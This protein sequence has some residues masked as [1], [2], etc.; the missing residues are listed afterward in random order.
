MIRDIS[1]VYVHIGNSIPDYLFDTIYQSLL[2]NGSQIKIYIIVNDD[3]IDMIKKKVQTFDFSQYINDFCFNSVLQFIPISIL[4]RSLENNSS[5]DQYKTVMNQK[6]SNLSHFRDGFWISTTARFYYIEMLI[7]M[8]HLQNVFHIENDVM[9]YEPIQ[10]IYK[11]INCNGHCD[12]D[13]ICMVQ[14]APDRVIPSLMFFPNLETTKELTKYITN[15]IVCSPNFINDMNILGSF[16]N[17]IELNIYPDQNDSN[18]NSNSNS[19]SKVV[20]DGAA[21]GQYLGGVDYKN[22]PDPDNLINQ[23]WNKSKGFVNE[24]CMM[25][26][27]DYIFHK[28]RIRL[29]HLDK[30]IL[31]YT[32]ENNQK[33]YKVAN[34]HI[35]SKQL[36]QHSSIFDINYEE[37]ITGDRIV[38][39]CDFVICTK[40]I[41]EFHKGI[42]DYA[43]DII[44]VKD[45]QKVNVQLLNTYF[46]NACFKNKNSTVKLFIYTHILNAFQYFILPHL[47]QSLQ[48][49]LYIHN[50]DH[51]LNDSH[52]PLINNNSIKHIYAQ[53]VDTSIISDKITLLPIGI[54]NSM[55]GHGDLV[56]LYTTIKNTYLYKKQK[57]IYVNINPN[58]YPYRKDILESIKNNNAFTLA[59]SKPYKDYLNELAQHYFCL[60]VRG[61]GIDTHRFWECLYLGV[62]PVIINNDTTKCDNFIYYLNKL[63]IPF[64][65]I[66]IDNVYDMFMKYTNSY[67]SEGLYKQIL[68]NLEYSIY[69]IPSLQISF[70]KEFKE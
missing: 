31:V 22:L 65:E 54:A 2:V 48:Y 56:S 10:N 35:H 42:D 20:F 8:F 70:Y 46:K 47:D 50:S 41:Y 18:S 53:N 38:S 15:E 55:W 13:K 3:N 51:S 12:I 61:N 21:I 34:L 60:C 40:E 1:L 19:N 28:S 66:K 9:L 37:I 39:L 59:N 24:T 67:F 30:S 7:E 33:L 52:I 36:Y 43:N 57:S 6:Y 27:T 32:I 69:T 62:I 17:K 23:Y 11:D 14:D 64:Y 4:D 16:P 26:P 44:I 63:E 5:F 45:F 25:K 29:D 68:K 58:T 49:I